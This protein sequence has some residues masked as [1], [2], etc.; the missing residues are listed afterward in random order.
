MIFYFNS[1]GTLIKANP[2][3]VFQGSNNANAI[4][5]VAPFA[6]SNTVLATFILPNGD[7]YKTPTLLTS[8]GAIDGVTLD[9]EEE[10][11]AIW[12]TYLT[13]P[14]TQYHGDLTCQFAVYD[15]SYQNGNAKAATEAVT[16][17][18]NKGVA[19]PLVAP[20]D[21]VYDQIADALAALTGRVAALEDWKTKLAGKS[22]V[23]TND[24]S[25]NAKP[26]PYSTSKTG[27]TFVKRLPDGRVKV[28]TAT[29]NDDAVPLSQVNDIV[30]DGLDIANELGQST[31]KA[32]SQKVV[33]DN[34]NATNA[35]AQTN[36]TNIAAINGKLATDEAN[37]A[38]N[39]ADI[40][41]KLDKNTGVTSYNQVYGKL[42]DGTWYMFNVASDA[43]AGAVVRYDGN[44]R[45]KVYDG[46][47][48]LDA[49]NKQQLDKKLDKTGGTVSGNLS[50]TGDLNVSGKT[51]TSE[52]TTQVVKN[53][54]IV[55]NSDGT[56]LTTKL[57]GVVIR[58]SSAATNNA[59]AIAYD[60][61][62]DSVKLGMGTVTSSGT[63]ENKVYSFTFASGEG[64]AVATRA[65]SSLLTTNHLLKW[66]ALSM[67]L[68]DSGLDA[69]KIGADKI[70]TVQFPYGAP[71]VTYDT[72]D[73]ISMSATMRLNVAG[74]NYDIPVDFTI[75]IFPGD[76]IN[77]DANA[78]SDGVKISLS[79]V[80]PITTAE[81]D[82]L[83][84]PAYD[85]TIT[86]TGS[87]TGGTKP[88]YI[89][90]DGGA[91]S[92]TDYDYKVGYR[93]DVVPPAIYNAQ[94]TFLSELPYVVHNVRTVG[95]KT[96]NPAGSSP[97]FINGIMT[98]SNPYTLT[99]D[100]EL[101]AVIKQAAKAPAKPTVK[102]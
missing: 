88:V 5:F 96:D 43:T 6:A 56:D 1:K 71:T 78:E 11:F 89:K 98:A 69:S 34:F 38:K 53:S 4:Y 97:V 39:T 52:E 58:T 54:I 32:V 16:I 70:R 30:A 29:E 22:V 2:E 40:A 61:A 80:T 35:K 23:Y 62:S 75:P 13:K 8:V 18:I 9:G 47:A 67:K 57:G 92:E 15:G 17:K 12:F 83:F 60:K 87:P 42:A 48:S 31:T 50:I 64:E 33:T 102:E 45:F 20:S 93:A 66:D 73:G 44:M 46:S 99:S 90:I 7:I 55:L 14:I 25:G 85:L 19:Q 95:W 100:T 3:A 91:A 86:Y 68:E 77:I 49:V 81:I 59:Y 82:F 51:I 27:S 41:K 63:G 21:T 36:A 101:K 24:A 26:E 37:I 10:D 65:D 76:N 79:D 94:G 84:L 72:T 74:T 28:Q